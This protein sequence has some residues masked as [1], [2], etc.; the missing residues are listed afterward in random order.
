MSVPA[1]CREVRFAVLSRERCDPAMPG[2]N[3]AG[4]ARQDI[5]EKPDECRSRQ[6]AGYS[7]RGFGNTG[8]QGKITCF[9]SWAA[10]RDRRGFFFFRALSLCR[11]SGFGSGGTDEE[12]VLDYPKSVI[13]LRARCPKASFP[14][15]ETGQASLMTDWII[16]LGRGLVRWKSGARCLRG[17]YHGR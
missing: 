17:Q 11:Q 10:S 15:S 9:H 8:I 2:C 16:S 3:R 14:Q 12:D 6:S 5:E 4:R 7:V 13:G 1:V